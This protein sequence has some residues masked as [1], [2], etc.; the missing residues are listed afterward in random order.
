RWLRA[1]PNPGRVQ[2]GARM[3]ALAQARG[4]AVLFLDDDYL[5]LD[6]AYLYRVWRILAREEAV[7]YGEGVLDLGSWEI[8]YRPGAPG[9]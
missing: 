9:R 4:E 7:V 2:V 1:L 5:L 6:P 3:Q 8:P